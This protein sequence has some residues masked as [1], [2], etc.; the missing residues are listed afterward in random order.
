[1]DE[2][3][4]RVVRDWIRSLPSL[5]NDTLELI[6]ARKAADENNSLLRRCVSSDRRAAMAKLLQTVTGALALLNHICSAADKKDLRQ[7]AAA[8]AASHPNALIRDLFQRLLPPEQ[9]RR[10]LGSDFSPQTVLAIE[11]HAARG[12]QIFTGQSQC[13]RCHT[14]KGAGRAFGPD[15]TGI[16][17]KYSRAQV[18]E[19][20]LY[21]SRNIAPEHR[22]TIVT[23]RDDSEITGFVLK[24]TSTELILR[25]ENL[26]EHKLK[27]PD[28]KDTRESALSAMPEGL[29]SSLTAQEAADLLEYLC[30]ANPRETNETK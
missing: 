14:C 18:L 10:T 23:L 13:S 15:L 25:D 29:L 3:G 5:T 8:L 27:L 26:T 4:T 9:R 28:L 24:R 11:G 12:E 22:T 30:G 1:V 2:A 7:E 16:C 21:P 6:A 17:Q 19:Q 20:I